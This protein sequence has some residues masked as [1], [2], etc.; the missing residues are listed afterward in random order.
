MSS[1]ENGSGRPLR[2]DAL[3]EIDSLDQLWQ[4][5]D[6]LYK[7][8][9]LLGVE[10]CHGI[11]FACETLEKRLKERAEGSRLITACHDRLRTEKTGSMSVDKLISRFNASIDMCLEY[12]RCVGEICKLLGADPVGACETLP[13]VIEDKIERY[14]KMI[15]DQETNETWHQSAAIKYKVDRESD[16][17]P[18]MIDRAITPEEAK[19]LVGVNE[20]RRSNVVLMTIALICLLTWIPSVWKNLPEWPAAKVYHLQHLSKDREI[21]KQM[22]PFYDECIEDNGSIGFWEYL[23][24]RNREAEIKRSRIIRE[25]R[26]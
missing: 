13:K 20:P 18:V 24:L 7:I 9:K 26:N 12:E 21:R 14:E 2:E 1:Q 25:M 17:E 8:F 6:G 16:G 19:Q 5:R 11:S 4:A 3:S 15:I 23:W 10:H 22:Q